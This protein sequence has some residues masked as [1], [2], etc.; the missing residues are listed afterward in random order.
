MRYLLTALLLFVPTSACSADHC[1]EHTPPPAFTP[2]S[3]EVDAPAN[4]AHG[5]LEKIEARAAEIETL[6]AKLRYD[7]N[8]LLLG[9]EQRRFGTLTYQAVPKTGFV[10]HFN[11]KLVD[12]HW[13]EPDLYYVYDGRWLLKADH[14]NKTA[15]RY[16]LVPDDQEVTEQIELGDGPFPIPLNLKK[17][18]V[19]AKYDALLVEP[20]EDD[21]EGSV[22]LILKPL[23]SIDSDLKMIELWFDQETL[24]P[25]RVSSLDDSGTQTVVNLSETEVNAALEDGLFDTSLPDEE[26][27]QT[28]ESRIAPAAD[29]E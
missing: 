15:N 7:N 20:A 21:P 9:D 10:I 29:D 8:Q 3:E 23:E 17:D 12:G 27:W 2:E 25:V 6:T 28:D 14:E 1:A 11:K 5:W 18:K 24:L 16:Q 4:P 19:L 13:T 26:G 22:H